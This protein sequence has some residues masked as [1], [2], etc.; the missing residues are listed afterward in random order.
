MKRLIYLALVLPVV[1]IAFACADAKDPAAPSTGVLAIESQHPLMGDPL[2]MAAT[3]DYVYIAEDQAGFSIWGR[4]NMQMYSR[5]LDFEVDIRNSKY[6][7]AIPEYKRIF[8]YNTTGTDGIYIFEVSD[9][10]TPVFT[11][12]ISGDTQSLGGIFFAVNN[13]DFTSQ[14][15]DSTSEIIGIRTNDNKFLYG[16]VDTENNLDAW[17]GAEAPLLTIY[18]PNDLRGIDEDENCFYLA[19]EQMGI[20]IIDKSTCTLAATCDTPGEALEVKVNGDVAYVADRQDGLSVIDISDPYNPVLLTDYCYNTTGYAQS[21][22]FE[23]DW[24][25]VGSGGGGVYLFD[26]STPAAPQFVDRLSTSSVGYTRCV[27]VQGGHVYVASRD[28]GLIDLSINP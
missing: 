7:C 18:M 22:D 26:I 4:T 6:L 9:P 12:W 16:Y 21:V 3:N 19:G 23:G 28:N 11:N 20:Y 8:V 25:A 2:D 5:N 17:H 24:L 1:V 27:D 13:H 15:Y 10:T 14:P